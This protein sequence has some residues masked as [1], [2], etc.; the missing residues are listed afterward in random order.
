[1]WWPTIALGDAAWTAFFI[2]VPVLVLDRFGHHPLIAGM[3]IASFGVG[4]LI[5]NGISFRFLTRRFAGLGVIA[6][7]AMFQ[8]LPLWLLWLPLPALGLAALILASLAIGTTAGILGVR[9][10]RAARRARP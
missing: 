10:W 3:L 1:M 6:T 8:A 5:G 7:F 2:T 9:A 4:A